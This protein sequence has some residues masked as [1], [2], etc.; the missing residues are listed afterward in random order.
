M[1]PSLLPQSCRPSPRKPFL[2]M[3]HLGTARRRGRTSPRE[4][5]TSRTSPTRPRPSVD[6]ARDSALRRVTRGVQSLASNSS[7]GGNFLADALG[8]RLHARP[9][10]RGSRR[11][12]N[13]STAGSLPFP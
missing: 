9:R 5:A 13:G 8:R 4:G 10:P 7:N 11:W 2:P 6:Q 3:R 1:A 12:N